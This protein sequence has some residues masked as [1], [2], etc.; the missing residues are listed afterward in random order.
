MRRT[1]HR[2]LAATVLAASAG[3]AQQPSASPVVQ[4]IKRFAD[5]YTPWI[6]AAF[7]SIPADKYGYKP[8]PAQQSVGYVAQHIESSAY[9]LCGLF[10]GSTHAGTARDSLSDTVKAKWPKDTLV[11]RVKAALMF[12]NEAFARV[13]DQMLADQVSFGAPGSS[14]VATR[15]LFGIGYV[16]DLADHYSQLANYMRLNGMLPPSA[17]RKPSS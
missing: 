12:C 3:A 11:T 10:G 8:T 5:Q 16:N 6:T 14:Q 13:T 2:V 9:A 15:A 1:L 7:D 4:S 17:R